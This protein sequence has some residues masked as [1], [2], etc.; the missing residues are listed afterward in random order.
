MQRKNMYIAVAVAIVVVAL[1][2]FLGL[3]GIGNTPAAAPDTSGSPAS[4]A[5]ALLDEISRTG[6]VSELSVIDT[7]V[8][9][10]AEAKAG[11]TITVNYTGVLP[12]GTM[13][14][15]SQG[16]GPFTF[17]LGVGQ[18]IKGWDQGVQGMKVG[19]TRLLAIP[20]ELA[21]GERAIGKI[22]AN[23]SLIFQVELVSVGAPAPQQ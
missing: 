18:V 19:G 3:F 1:F 7:V 6:T 10:G 2:M 8:G 16:R 13:F 15:S 22:P 23:S 9:S 11:D 5:Q 12:D 14:D 21:Y 17:T 20:A 4:S